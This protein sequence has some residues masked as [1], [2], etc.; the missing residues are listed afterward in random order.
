MLLISLQ[1]YSLHSHY[2]QTVTTPVNYCPTSTKSA[3]STRLARTPSRPAISGREVE[4][5]ISKGTGLHHQMSAKWVLLRWLSALRTRHTPC[6]PMPVPAGCESTE[7]PEEFD[8]GRAVVPEVPDQRFASCYLDRSTLEDQWCRREEDVGGR[9]WEVMGPT[10]RSAISEFSPTWKRSQDI[11]WDQFLGAR[12][13]QHRLKAFLFLLKVLSMVF[14]LGA[15]G[16][17]TCGLRISQFAWLEGAVGKCWRTCGL[18]WQCSV[19][20]FSPACSSC[21]PFQIPR[22]LGLCVECICSR[23]IHFSMV[24]GYQ[25]SSP[26]PSPIWEMCRPVSSW[27]KEQHSEW[28]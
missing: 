21:S 9:N 1:V 2:H 20:G 14:L 13:N 15:V 4:V 6:R 3:D 10:W 27:K 5:A 22:I 19:E 11:T 7:A 28:V 24:W 16:K 17:R 23:S 18:L 12:S 8:G 25:K 26:N